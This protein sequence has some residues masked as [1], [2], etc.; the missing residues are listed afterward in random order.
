[1]AVR[2]ERTTRGR[3]IERRFPSGNRRFFIPLRFLAPQGLYPLGAAALTGA[4]TT[5]VA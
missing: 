2:S 3:H 4:Y 1:M 5:Y